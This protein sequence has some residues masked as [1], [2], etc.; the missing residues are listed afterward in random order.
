MTGEGT[1]PTPNIVHG[2]DKTGYLHFNEEILTVD[3]WVSDEFIEIYKD[4]AIISDDVLRSYTIDRGQQ[5]F[6]VQ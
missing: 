3:S 5:Q 2:M 4:E 1:R 6:P